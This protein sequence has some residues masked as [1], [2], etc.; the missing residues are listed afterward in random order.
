MQALPL[1]S[2]P[3]WAPVAKLPGSLSLV[4]FAQHGVL[5][6]AQGASCP[7]WLSS[8]ATSPT[9]EG[10][11]GYAI[12]V[13]SILTFL[14]NPYPWMPDG[15]PKNITINGR[16]E[17]QWSQ[18]SAVKSPSGFSLTLSDD[19]L[20]GPQSWFNQDSLWSAGQA[21]GPREMPDATAKYYQKAQVSNF[22]RNKH[23]NRLTL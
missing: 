23:I 14:V 11:W 10:L 6:S 2:E 9:S 7:E 5:P 1:R 16:G 21:Q 3:R 12:I 15:S 22:W 13:A 4:A 19:W 8:A 17:G 20:P 18:E